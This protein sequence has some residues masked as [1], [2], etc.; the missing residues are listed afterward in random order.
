MKKFTKVIALTVVAIMALAVS[1]SASKVD[2][3]G[4]KMLD[5]VSY[6]AKLDEYGGTNTLELEYVQGIPGNMTYVNEATPFG[7]KGY[8]SHT[9]DASTANADSLFQFGTGNGTLNG[10]ASGT[11]C[12][13]LPGNLGRQKIEVIFRITDVTNAS[14]AANAEIFDIRNFFV[15]NDKST[16]VIGMKVSGVSGNTLSWQGR[17]D[18]D[19]TDKNLGSLNTGEWYRYVIL[20]DVPGNVQNMYIEKWNSSTNKFEIARDALELKD[21]RTCEGR[22][23]Y[24]YTSSVRVR[25]TNLM[26]W[27]IAQVKITRDN[28]LAYKNSP[29]ATYSTPSDRYNQVKT[30][31]I[32]NFNGD[33]GTTIVGRT[34]VAGNAFG[35]DANQQPTKWYTY[36]DGTYEPKT[37]NPVLIVAQYDESGNLITVNTASDT[38][39]T[40]NAGYRGNSVVSCDPDATPTAATEYNAVM[41]H[42]LDFKTLEIRAPKADGVKFAKIYLWSGTSN[43]VPLTEA[44]ELK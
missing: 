8:L 41:Q 6:E 15:K 16:A 32:T 42:E 24:C 31:V 35:L 17:F 2:D 21:N 25:L 30:G 29:T 44:T 14:Q 36:E 9:Y 28:T 20:E 13:R 39:S 43:M 11:L 10:V 38:I 12:S 18:S 40:L 37:T 26:S 19:E 1:A 22:N 5:P 27:D 4:F 7:T 3:I 33:S 34:Y 23:A